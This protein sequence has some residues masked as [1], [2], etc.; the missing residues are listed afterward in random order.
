MVGWWKETIACGTLASHAAHLLTGQIR[1]E[2]RIA[3]SV[4][5]GYGGEGGGKRMFGVN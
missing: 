5:K 4:S 1:R 2:Q 3:H